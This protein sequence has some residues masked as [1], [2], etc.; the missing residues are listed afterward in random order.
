MQLLL[1]CFVSGNYLV[2]KN[3]PCLWFAKHNKCQIVQG[4][5]MFALLSEII[6]FF[7]LHLVP[8]LSFGDTLATCKRRGLFLEVLVAVT[9]RLKIF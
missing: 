3:P 9:N 5:Q 1:F 6:P 2:S 8:H 4:L 7:V